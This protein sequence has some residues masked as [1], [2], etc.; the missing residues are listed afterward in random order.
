MLSMEDT[1]LFLLDLYA[2][3]GFIKYASMANE[4][5]FRRIMFMVI[6]ILSIN[7]TLSFLHRRINLKMPEIFS[8]MP[9]TYILLYYGFRRIQ[10][11]EAD[12]F[13]RLSRLNLYLFLLSISFA[14]FL[15]ALARDFAVSIRWFVVA[16]LLMGGAAIAV[17]KFY[18]EVKLFK[19]LSVKYE[20]SVPT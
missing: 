10:N 1:A 3:L 16:P 7:F 20:R 14:L 9:L 17:A 19:H 8:L 18:W 4:D 2:Y 15:I 12:F 13:R 5:R 11:A 6:S